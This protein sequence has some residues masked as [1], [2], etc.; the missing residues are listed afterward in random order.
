MLNRAGFTLAEV[1]IAIVLFAA[2]ISMTYGAYNATFK[3]ISTADASSRYAER[4]RITLERLTA[5][6]AS[7]YFGADGMLEGESTFYGEYR[8]AELTF[9]SRA[10]LLL[11][12]NAQPKA[13]AR[14]A[15]TVEEDGGDGLLRLYRS[16]VPLLPGVPPPEQQQGFLLCEG[17][18]EL[19]ITY[20]DHDGNESD[21][22]SSQRRSEEGTG[23]VLPA[24]VRLTLGFAE[25]ATE[26]DPVRFTSAVALPG[27]V[28]S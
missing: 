14:I 23:P 17:L 25:S 15:Y 12:R 11:T 13:V 22:W 19:Q 4:A 18:R 2:V 26:E 8:A 20:V 1:L 24:L 7:V 3:V 9:T 27:G 5:D 16:D 6:L 21:S 28:T 10:H